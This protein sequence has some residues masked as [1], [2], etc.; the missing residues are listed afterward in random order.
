LI[1]DRGADPYLLIEV[2]LEGAVRALAAHVP[3]ERQGKTTEQL[4]RL[5]VERLRV[6][7]PA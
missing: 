7:G 5:L 3:P 1:A 2:L 6:H 4:R